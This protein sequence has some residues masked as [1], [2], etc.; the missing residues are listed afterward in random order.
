[1]KFEKIL[2]SKYFYYLAVFLMV[3]NVMGY[4]ST[5][6][7]ECVLVF[8]AAAY[9]G[10]QYTKNNAVGIFIGLFVSNILFGCGRVREG[11]A[12]KSSTELAKKAAA[13]AKTEERCKGLSGASLKKCQA[14][15]VKSTVLAKAA[16]VADKADK[17]GAAKKKIAG[18]AKAAVSPKKKK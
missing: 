11:L 8:G 10:T 15:K 14:A 5:Q 12:D 18:A 16:D 2:K 7:L 13:T 6:S 1:M 9:A 4:V 17:A 3:T